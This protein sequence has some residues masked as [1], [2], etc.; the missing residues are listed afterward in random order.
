MTIERHGHSGLRALLD[1]RIAAHDKPGAVSAALD[2]IERGEVDIPALHA[3]LGDLLVD[4]GAAWQEG[5]CSVW[6]EHLAS[7]TIRT[8]V[9]AVY[10][11]LPRP[12]PAPARTVVLACPQDE[13]H[14]LGLRML[15]DRFELAGW[16]TQMVGADTPSGELAAAARALGAELIVL[17]ASTHFHRI[18]IKRILDDLHSALPG[19]R[20]VVG[21]AAFSR[22]CC[23]LDDD[24]L[25]RPEEFFGPGADARSDDGPVG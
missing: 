6:E 7:G 9:E 13:S 10:P 2:A 24:E 21:G 17:S 14:D 12:E 19:V 16:R 23:G 5:T 4:I 18:R 15:S 3:L 8:I 22:D 20:V 11:G 1:E 25:M